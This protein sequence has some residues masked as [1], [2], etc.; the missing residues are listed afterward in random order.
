[1]NAGE[2]RLH[3]K[4]AKDALITSDRIHSRASPRQKPISVSL[5]HGPPAFPDGTTT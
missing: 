4:N 5:K 3:R 1:M 2:N